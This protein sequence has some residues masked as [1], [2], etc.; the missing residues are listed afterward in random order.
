VRVVLDT[1]VVVSRYWSPNG[2]AAQILGLLRQR[3]FDL[4]LSS[5]ILREYDRVLRY[6]K[7][8]ALHRM[9]DAE[10][11]RVIDD[12]REV[13]F[14]VY[15]EERLSIIPRDPDDNMFVECALLGRAQFIISGD[16]HLLNLG[17]YE[18]IEI[19]PPADFVR[20]FTDEHPANPLLP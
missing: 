4:I 1:N 19:L 16:K 11:T 10:I 9:N 7:I 20:L 15:P 17:S 14:M 6:P 12:F 8:R 5:D 18:Q 2:V 3:R 13:A